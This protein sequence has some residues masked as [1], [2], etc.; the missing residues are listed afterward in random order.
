MCQ[1]D[2]R[3][4]CTGKAGLRLKIQCF[5]CVLLSFFNYYYC[6][7]E[8]RYIGVFAKVLTIYLIYH[9]WIQA[10]CWFSPPP[11][12]PRTVSTVI[13]FAF[14]YMCI[15]YLNHLSPTSISGLSKWRMVW[16]PSKFVCEK[17][18]FQCS[19]GDQ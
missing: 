9:I 14:T 11:L 4:T 3:N 5:V 16:F 13:I 15:N 8:L 12:I 6:C 2:D 17:F 19:R 10:L 18:H 7:A 1:I